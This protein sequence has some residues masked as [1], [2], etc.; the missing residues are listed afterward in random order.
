MNRLTEIITA[1]RREV[2]LLRPR[3]ETLRRTALKRNDFR[4]F[5]SALQRSDEN[6]AVVAEIKKASPSA[7]TIVQTFA[8]AEIAR[9]YEDGGAGAISVLTDTAFFQGNLVHL[10]EARAAVAL[11]VLRKDFVIDEI[12]IAEACT[13]GADAVLLIVAA[14]EKSQLSQLADAAARYQLDALVEVHTLEEMESAL[15]LGAEIIGINNRDLTT[16][17]IDLAVTE[18]LSEEVPNDV[19]LV[20]ESGLRT[21]ADIARVRACG[22]DAVL[23]GEALMRGQLSIDTITASQ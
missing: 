4:G 14:L 11:P 8:P 17:Q 22:V 15:E 6:L 12:Q 23:V 13:A 5:K 21:P 9:G 10:T 19:V 20:S 18:R 3:A 16:L 7:G 1:K 2:E